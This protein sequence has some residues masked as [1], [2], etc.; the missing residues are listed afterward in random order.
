ME[1]NGIEK[2]LAAVRLEGVLSYIGTRNKSAGLIVKDAN[3]AD[4]IKP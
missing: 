4:D 1:H 3:C 2:V